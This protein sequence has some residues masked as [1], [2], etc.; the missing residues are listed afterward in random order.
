M[1]ETKKFV[2][3][4]TI[5]NTNLP[6]SLIDKCR[7]VYKRYGKY[8]LYDIINADLNNYAKYTREER[9]RFKSIELTRRYLYLYRKAMAETLSFAYNIDQ[10]EL[11][12]ETLKEFD[13]TNI[14]PYCER[15]LTMVSQ[16]GQF[17]GFPKSHYNDVYKKYDKIVLFNRYPV[18]KSITISLSDYLNNVT[19]NTI[20]GYTFN[21]WSLD[22]DDNRENLAEIRI[23][24]SDINIKITDEMYAVMTEEDRNKIIMKSDASIFNFVNTDTSSQYYGQIRIYAIYKSNTDNS[25][26]STE[27]NFTV[28]LE[29]I[30]NIYSSSLT[31]VD[32]SYKDAFDLLNIKSDHYSFGYFVHDDNPDENYITDIEDNSDKN[33][34]NYDNGNKETNII[35]IYY[36]NS[37][38]DADYVDYNKTIRQFAIEYLKEPYLTDIVYSTDDNGNRTEIEVGTYSFFQ[39]SLDDEASVF[40]L[41]DDRSLQLI[42]DV[43]S[44]K[45]NDVF[46][47]YALFKYDIKDNTRAYDDDCYATTYR[48]Y[49]GIDKSYSKKLYTEYY[50]NDDNVTG[51]NK[52]ITAKEYSLLSDEDKSKYTAQESY[53]G[54][55]GY[56]AEAGSSNAVVR[57]F[58]LRVILCSKDIKES[59]Q[60]I[61]HDSK[62]NLTGV[63]L[64]GTTPGDY[65][66]FYNLD[67]KLWK[68]YNDDEISNSNKV[69]AAWINNADTEKVVYEDPKDDANWTKYIS[70]RYINRNEYLALSDDNKLRCTVNKLY[71]TYTWRND[72]Y[73]VSSGASSTESIYTIYELQ[74][75][76][77]VE[78]YNKQTGTPDGSY[79]VDTHDYADITNETYRLYKYYLNQDTN[80]SLD[81]DDLK[82]DYDLTDYAN[83][84]ETT[85]SGDTWLYPINENNINSFKKFIASA[86]DIENHN[87]FKRIGNYYFYVND[88]NLEVS[89]THLWPIDNTGEHQLNYRVSDLWKCAAFVDGTVL[90]YK[91]HTWKEDNA[92]QIIASTPNV[93]LKLVA[94]KYNTSVSMDIVNEINDNG[95]Y[96]LRYDNITFT[97]PGLETYNYYDNSEYNVTIPDT[98]VL[99]KYSNIS[100]KLK[101]PVDYSTGK[102]K[103]RR[104]YIPANKDDPLYGQSEYQEYG[105]GTRVY[106]LINATTGEEGWVNWSDIS[107]TSILY[108][109]ETQDE[110]NKRVSK[111][112][113]E[114]ETYEV[115]L[116]GKKYDATNQASY[117]LANT[118]TSNYVKWYSS[119]DASFKR[120]DGMIVASVSGG[121][122]DATKEQYDP[123]TNPLDNEGNDLFITV[124]ET[125]LNGGVRKLS[126]SY[127]GDAEAVSK[128]NQ[129]VSTEITNIE[130][131]DSRVWWNQFSK[132]LTDPQEKNEYITNVGINFC[133]WIW[134]GWDNPENFQKSTNPVPSNEG[135]V[136]SYVFDDVD[137]YISLGFQRILY[138]TQFNK[139]YYTNDGS[140]LINDKTS[141]EPIK[142]LRY[143]DN[144]ECISVK[145][146]LHKTKWSY[147]NAGATVFQS[148]S[149]Y[150]M[151]LFSLDEYKIS[152]LNG[153]DKAIDPIEAT[154]GLSSKSQ[155]KTLNVLENESFTGESY[156]IEGFTLDNYP[157]HYRLSGDNPD[158]KMRYM[159]HRGGWGVPDDKRFEFEYKY[160][161]DE[162]SPTKMAGYKSNI[163]EYIKYNDYLKLNHLKNIKQI[164]NIPSDK[165]DGDIVPMK[166][167]PIEE[168]QNRYKDVLFNTFE[169]VYIQLNSSI[170]PYS[171][172]NQ[173]EISLFNS[174]LSDLFTYDKLNPS[175]KDYIDFKLEIINLMN[176]I[177]DYEFYK[178]KYWD[179]EK[180]NTY[181]LNKKLLKVY[182]DE[183]KL[184]NDSSEINL[185]ELEF[186]NFVKNKLKYYTVQI[187]KDT[188][189][190]Y[191]NRPLYKFIVKK[192]YNALIT[193]TI[194]EAMASF[195]DIPTYKNIK[196]VGWAKDELGRS[197]YNLESNEINQVIRINESVD[198]YLVY[199]KADYYSDDST[200]KT[201]NKY[202]LNDY[203]ETLETSEKAK[204]KPVNN[205]VVDS[206][207]MDYLIYSENGNDIFLKTNFQD[208]FS[209]MWYYGKSITENKIKETLSELHEKLALPTEFMCCLFNFIIASKKYNIVVDD[210]GN[211]GSLFTSTGI[212]STTSNGNSLSVVKSADSNE[213]I[214][215]VVSKPWKFATDDD[216][217]R[218]VYEQYLVLYN[219][220][221][222]D[223]YSFFNEG[224]LKDIYGTNNASVKFPLYQFTSNP[225]ETLYSDSILLDI[226]P[227]T[228][229]IYESAL[230]LIYNKGIEIVDLANAKWVTNNSTIISTFKLFGNSNTN[231]VSCKLDEFNNELKLILVSNN[232]EI[233]TYDLKNDVYCDYNQCKYANNSAYLGYRIG[234]NTEVVETS[235]VVKARAKLNSFIFPS[236]ETNIDT[237]PL[238]KRIGL[239][240]EFATLKHDKDFDGKPWVLKNGITSTVVTPSEISDDY[241]DTL[242]DENKEKYNIHPKLTVKY[243]WN[244]QKIDDIDIPKNKDHVYRD[245]Y[246]GEFTKS[247]E[248]DFEV[249]KDGKQISV[250]EYFNYSDD[251]ERKKCTIYQLTTI[252]YTFVRL[253]FHK[254]G[255][256]IYDEE[257]SARLTSDKTIYAFYYQTGEVVDPYY[258]YKIQ[259]SENIINGSDTIYSD[260]FNEYLKTNKAIESGS[261]FSE[262]KTMD[263]YKTNNPDTEYKGSFISNIPMMNGI[264]KVYPI[265]G[266]YDSASNKYIPYYIFT[267]GYKIQ[268]VYL[269]DLKLYMFAE[270]E[271]SDNNELI[272]VKSVSGEM[273]IY[274]IFKNQRIVELHTSEYIPSEFSAA[275][276][277]NDIDL[278]VKT[279]NPSN[280]KVE[281][282]MTEDNR[283]VNSYFNYSASKSVLS[284]NALIKSTSEYAGYN[285]SKVVSVIV[286][287]I[288]QTDGSKFVPK[289]HRWKKYLGNDS[290]KYMISQIN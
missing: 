95:E 216:T 62:G 56:P 162:Y 115:K 44:V 159:M 263:N 63:F 152:L 195:G 262:I 160:A 290:T 70:G 23:L 55:R 186:E 7:E 172:F 185:S 54:Y 144:P 75:C 189:H 289:N 45:N 196:F 270:I 275:S 204:Y 32:G 284:E 208:K 96:Q 176:D 197:F 277:F 236:Q 286:T 79:G 288:F 280:N 134:L 135:L 205:I 238:K 177:G 198:F 61:S 69:V 169:N 273:K 242:S 254:N 121:Y 89:T 264:N 104:T 24:P 157:W 18:K 171:Q 122:P 88:L 156:D 137:N 127:S 1:S 184:I 140:T 35:V 154:F 258:G 77:S 183:S 207:L 155:L 6:Q 85:Y 99:I 191:E 47:I 102:I 163:S 193:T 147:Q 206:T 272:D 107:D 118:D 226:V 16:I 78:Q 247:T 113:E 76:K 28:T 43:E 151:N 222:F 126:V 98:T 124:S 173:E 237:V 232:S 25:Y 12:D 26:T 214:G 253:S 249:Y 84:F 9:K 74:N 131:L 3:I 218:N 67:K 2:S 174:I 21:Y 201:D 213:Y 149:P 141:N 34:V 256:G 53:V 117:D 64:S 245:I 165:Y 250:D 192:H 116:L 123:S 235:E 73:T 281:S 287:E 39:W 212:K 164:S 91:H 10:T 92:T 94:Y 168:Y 188:W 65:S 15:P 200:V 220:N 138:P 11:I 150:A 114:N 133:G 182:L 105:I 83:E 274:L 223:A 146:R 228:S 19:P 27:Y 31:N 175:S 132:L 259:I 279:D 219:T 22:R 68:I 111:I 248:G 234:G 41:E 179:E 244:T 36:A 271:Y 278:I 82:L 199:S 106:A 194:A 209:K 233:A 5:D 97:G 51:E 255:T 87:R 187:T 50:C 241:Y 120:S 240:I 48:S 227:F 181:S 139:T 20:L 167:R 229:D 59:T 125:I 38:E 37:V 210:K 243:A 143:C 239:V 246:T 265:N 101:V 261:S 29:D 57:D 276:S 72:T 268:I 58:K 13:N 170:S 211:V 119:S 100:E 283:I 4:P 178:S 86:T 60:C 285:N 108:R 30:F 81:E 14:C 251:E 221:T 225:I 282:Y 202:I 66:I 93:A 224:W 217:G 103:V 180:L 161:T 33:I 260:I 46:T 8:R 142:L 266:F 90:I 136:E 231:I 145:K 252:N 267:D 130:E 257:L 71:P 230:A 148:T 49:R 80:V 129:S 158:Q 269:K 190:W 52:Y 17:K 42:Q 110:F 109:D 203:Y 215:A 40:I 128:N 166:E 112:K 153:L